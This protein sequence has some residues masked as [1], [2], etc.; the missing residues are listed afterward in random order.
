MKLLQDL[1]LAP[2]KLI[3][4]F[5]ICVRVYL[6]FLNYLHYEDQMA[7]QVIGPTSK[8]YIMGNNFCIYF[9]NKN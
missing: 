2:F 6:V 1:T 7:P 5:D 8:F 4:V 3:Q 9:F